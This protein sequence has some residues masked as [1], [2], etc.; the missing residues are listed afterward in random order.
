MGRRCGIP[1]PQGSQVG[2]KVNTDPWMGHLLLWASSSGTPVCYMNIIILYV[3][4]WKRGWK[5]L[6]PKMYLDMKVLCFRI[7]T[8]SSIIIAKLFSKIIVPIYMPMLP[9][10]K[11]FCQFHRYEMLS[12]FNLHLPDKSGSPFICLLACLW[13]VNWLF[14][15]FAHFTIELFLLLTDLQWLSILDINILLVI[16]ICKLWLTFYF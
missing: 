14:L 6:P 16:C 4:W 1:S 15:S 3:P 13:F 12:C 8:F 2:P 10:L 5:T 9:D 11:N 7:S